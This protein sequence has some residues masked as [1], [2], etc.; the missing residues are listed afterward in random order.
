MRVRVPVPS[1]RL[2][3][4]MLISLV[5]LPALGLLAYT[6]IERRNTDAELARS[7]AVQIAR[8][9]GAEY[10]GVV[11]STQA[12]I[13]PVTTLLSQTSSLAEVP[14][15]VCIA[16]FDAYL[17]NDT[18]YASVHLVAPDG[19]VSC[20]SKPLNESISFAETSAFHMAMQSTEALVGTYQLDPL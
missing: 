13:R 10:L 14:P 8:D 4:V 7:R 16:F 18:P 3:L 15:D 17:V 12:L 2:Q 11:T 9:V 20:A 1:L 19:A 6:G 5:A